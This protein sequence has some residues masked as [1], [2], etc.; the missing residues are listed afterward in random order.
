[1]H[2]TQSSWITLIKINTSLQYKTN[3]F[4][5]L[6]AVWLAR[7]N[8]HFPCSKPQL[9]RSYGP[10]FHFIFKLLQSKGQTRKLGNQKWCF[11]PP[12][13]SPLFLFFYYTLCLFSLQRSNSPLLCRKLSKPKTLKWK[14][15]HLQ[16]G[17]LPLRE[18]CNGR[19]KSNGL[20]LEHW[21][22]ATTSYTVHSIEMIILYPAP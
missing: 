17:C 15:K 22:L 3:Y 7:N 9:S 21:H 16:L 2:L 18:K 11:Q 12:P 19:V 4:S 1:M 6:Q 10:N 20:F 13:L 5:K 14:R 8:P